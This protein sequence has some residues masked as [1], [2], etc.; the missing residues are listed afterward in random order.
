MNNRDSNFEEK[1]EDSPFDEKKDEE[2]VWTYRGYHLGPTQFTTSMVHL[3]RGE[4]ARANVWRQRLDTT[5]NWAV[6][7][8]GA[9]VS[10][11]FANPNNHFV[12]LL[13]AILVTVFLLIESRRYRYY[14]L[15]SYRIRLMETDFFASMLVPPFH[16]GSDWAETLAESL[17]HPKFPISR[18]EAIGRRLRHNYLWIY[19]FIFLVWLLKLWLLPTHTNSFSE[20]SSRAKIGS[21]PGLI[22]V[23]TIFALFV[24]ILIFS[25]FTLPLQEASGEILPKYR[26][27]VVSEENVK[28]RKKGAWFRPSKK[29]LRVLAYIITDNQE[30]ISKEILQ[31]MHRGVTAL[32]GMGMHSKESHS[33][34]LCAIT[35][36]EIEYLKS[37]VNQVDP[38]SFVIITSAI[39]VFGKGFTEME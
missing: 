36:T 9:A 6:I 31:N 24:A 32:P 21:I 10:I 30:A 37:I 17:L 1:R 22:I 33:V 38:D 19:I 25:L 12:I 26:S 16:P 13:N 18:M 35:E 39:D 3:Y 23:T 34:L 14:E 8:T 20:F 2:N 27:L 28:N 15:W 11:A 5:T 29:R 7:T 4:I